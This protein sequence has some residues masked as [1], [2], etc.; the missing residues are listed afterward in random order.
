MI[1]LKKYWLTISDIT[2]IKPHD[3]L[4]VLL[5][6]HDNVWDN[7][8]K[9]NKLYKPETFFKNSKDTYIHKKDL[10]GDL[11]FN[12]IMKKDITLDVEYKK[13]E[14]YPL[15]N[16]YLPAKHQ[17]KRTRLLGKKTHWTELNKKTLVGFKGPIMLW[18]DLKR[19]LIKN[20]SI[21]L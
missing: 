19:C 11:K 20:I 3:K 1:N 14:W 21:D 9:D 17:H 5:S 16:G 12:G 8:L 18:S 10:V 13:G 15:Q 4:G 6:L 7:L 2:R